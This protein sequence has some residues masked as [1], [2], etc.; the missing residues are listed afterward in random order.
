MTVKELYEI[1]KNLMF[2]KKTSRD[3]DGYYMLW[4]NVLLSEQFDLN[5]HLRLKHDKD[6]LEKIPTVSNDDDVIPYEHEMCYEILPFGLAQNFFIDDDLAKYDIFHT[7]YE[8]AMSKYMWG[9]EVTVE[10]VY[11]AVD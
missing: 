4:I 10:D 8:N 6:I 2:E 7:Y 1:A 11:G 3:Y 5:N 9:V